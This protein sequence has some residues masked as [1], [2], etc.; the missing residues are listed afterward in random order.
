MHLK[1][2]RL[3]DGK[4]LWMGCLGLLRGC[5]RSRQEDWLKEQINLT[6]KEEAQL[7]L[8]CVL[9]LA[10]PMI[11]DL[12]RALSKSVQDSYTFFWKECNLGEKRSQWK[13][14]VC[15]SGP[16]QIFFIY[17]A[18]SLTFDHLLREIGHSNVFCGHAIPNRVLYVRF[19]NS[20]V[21]LL[22]S[23]KALYQ[24]TRRGVFALQ[25]TSAKF[26]LY[27]L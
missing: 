1:I 25:L 18:S 20:K 23:Q 6:L 24:I 21:G 5:K 4:K 19:H 16:H 22:R 8:G 10:W 27:V 14:F 7:P 2:C 9:C 12:G 3:V 13:G 17:I 26:L 11:I 15:G